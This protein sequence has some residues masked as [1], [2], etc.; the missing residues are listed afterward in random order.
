MNTE[1]QTI[2][3]VD[4]DPSIRKAMTRALESRGYAIESFE[5]AEVF[6][7][8]YDPTRSGCLVLDLSMPGMDGLELQQALIKR[9]SSIPIIFITGHGSVPQSVIAL[10]SGAIDFLE[11]P[12]KQ[13]VLLERVEEAFVEDRRMRDQGQE[14]SAAK[15]RV[16][17]LTNRELEVMRL[18]V[19][20]PSNLSSKQVARELKISPRTVDHHRARVM[21]KMQA[22]SITELTSLAE[23]AGL[24]RKHQS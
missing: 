16:A 13:E 21:E 5:S 6:L 24:I 10:K 14:T 4:D 17:L 19:S 9:G 8:Q 1:K 23:R 22:R 2:F 12:F 20:D 11:K 15:G 7:E 18:L 3:L